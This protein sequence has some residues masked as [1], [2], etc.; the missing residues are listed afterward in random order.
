M[1]TTRHEKEATMNRLGS[2]TNSVQNN[3]KG[4]LALGFEQGFLKLYD[5][6]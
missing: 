3:M 5:L 2:N 1:G 6:S 4:D